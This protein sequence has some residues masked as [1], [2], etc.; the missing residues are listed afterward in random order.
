MRELRDTQ[1]SFQW[2]HLAGLLCRP[3]CGYMAK[4]WT[5]EM[6]ILWFLPLTSSRQIAYPQGEVKADHIWGMK[7]M[8]SVD[9]GRGMQRE[10]KLSQR[11]EHP[12]IEKNGDNLSL[13]R[14][15]IQGWW[16]YKKNPYFHI[17]FVSSTTYL[18]T[19]LSIHSK[20]SCPI[21]II[22][23]WLKAR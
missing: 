19:K 13:F 3:G 9:P 8:S 21:Q 17:L 4:I 15:K 22:Y 6:V 11:S 12:I 16:R 7:W 1:R 18:K 14:H 10:L 5:D 20:S 2:G 23:P